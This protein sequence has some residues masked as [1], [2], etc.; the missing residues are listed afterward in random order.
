MA[1]F[2]VYSDLHYEFG[3][4]FMPPAHLKGTV[5]GVIL[6]GDISGGV[7]AMRHARQIS[8]AIEAPAV[9]ITGNHEFYGNVIECLV[10]ELR[11]LSDEQVRFLECDAT[12]IA[13]VRF[14][15]T[16]LWT[17]YNLNP[18]LYLKAMSDISWMMNDYKKIH[19]FLSANGN[20]HIDTDYVLS[21]HIKCRDWLKNELDKAHDGPTFVVTHTAPSRKS[22]RS[23]S[24]YQTISAA[25][26]SDLEQFIHS[27]DINVWAHGHIHDSV[28]Y[29]VGNTR[30][31]SNPYGYERFE[32]NKQFVDD[33]VIKL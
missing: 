2:L 29:M 32:Q 17:D 27:H 4:R 30:V 20:I 9:L 3:S 8:D 10:D 6:A 11:A 23:H 22:I 1:R 21:E 18:H 15:G 31:V 7:H 12:E 16:T 5:D 13:G 25:F 33:F 24:S 26:A 28:D 14:L 19:R